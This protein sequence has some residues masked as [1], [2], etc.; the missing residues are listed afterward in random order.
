MRA[1]PAALVQKEPE[2]YSADEKEAAQQAI[3]NA[4]AAALANN[5]KALADAI[6]ANTKSQQDH[7]DSFRDLTSKEIEPTH[8][9]VLG[10]AEKENTDKQKALQDVVDKHAATVLKAA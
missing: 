3:D 4:N 9:K 8:A 1:E 5:Q 2:D 7:I 6:K 10:E